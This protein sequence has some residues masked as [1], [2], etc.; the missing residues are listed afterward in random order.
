MKKILITGASGYLGSAVA[1][2]LSNTGYECIKLVRNPG[3]ADEAFFDLNRPVEETIFENAEFLIHAAWDFSANRSWEKTYHTN[4]AGSTRLFDLA[5]KRGVKIIFISTMSSFESC[6]SFYGRSKW[7]LEQ[8]LLSLRGENYIIKPG[9]I[10]G[11]VLGGV[12][13]Q[14]YQITKF[15][16]V[17]LIQ[18]KNPFFLVD[19]KDVSRLMLSVIDGTQKILINQPVAAAHPRPFDIR[20]LLVL[21]GVRNFIPFPWQM[22][23]IGLKFFEMIKIQLRMSSDSLMNLVHQNPEPDFRNTEKSR[24]CFSDVEEYQVKNWL[25]R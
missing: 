20:D 8:Y 14:L 16:Y 24:I 12:T 21:M 13:R 7:M 18:I 17:P 25:K 19:H 4:V 11:D 3:C 1:D 15:P 23:W 5:T 10:Y 9:L 6:V 2:V 22:I